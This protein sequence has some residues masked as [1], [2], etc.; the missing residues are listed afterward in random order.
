MLMGLKSIREVQNYVHDVKKML[1]QFKKKCP[2]VQN[3]VCHTSK[4]VFPSPN[5]YSVRV[6]NVR[7]VQTKCRLLEKI[8]WVDQNYCLVVHKEM[9]T[10]YKKKFILSKRKQK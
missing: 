10:H 5:E 9:F 3:D 7:I 4:K 8:V 1:L 6:K 2:R